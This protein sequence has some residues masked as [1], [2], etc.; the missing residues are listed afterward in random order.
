[1]LGPCRMKYSLWKED[2]ELVKS[3]YILSKKDIYGLDYIKRL[4]DAGVSSLKIEGRNKLP[5]YVAGV[6]K[7]YRKYIDKV[8]VKT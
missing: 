5:E 2:K 4:I 7:T 1:M 8:I 3:T 6:T